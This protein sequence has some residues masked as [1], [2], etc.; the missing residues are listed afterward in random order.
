MLQAKELECE[1]GGRKL[2][3]PLSFG[4]SGGELLRISGPNGSGKTSLLRILCGLLTPTQGEVRWKGAPIAGLRE[5]YSRDLVYLGHAPAVKDEL[6]PR[7]NLEIA[8]RLAG[9][10]VQRNSIAQA[11][12]AY[13]VPDLPARK[14]S[15][16]QRRR[17]ALARLVVSQS[18]P[19]WLLDEPFAALDPAAA[20]FT[21]RLIDEHVAAGAAVAY[22]THQPSTLDGK[23]RVVDLAS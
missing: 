10:D 21:E 5:D 3:G 9:A 13:S 20:Q 7:E 1:R 19:L 12:S 2:F 22:T 15:Q 6:T 4:L 23:A 17:A 18:V 8:C 16:G 14:L 11:L